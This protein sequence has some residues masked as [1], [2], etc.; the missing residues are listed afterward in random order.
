[1]INKKN[2]EAE[3]EKLRGK[4]RYQ[5]RLAEERE[6]DRLIDDYKHK[7]PEEPEIDAEEI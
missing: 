3:N 7:P 2:T 5:E 1:M 4:K 6:A